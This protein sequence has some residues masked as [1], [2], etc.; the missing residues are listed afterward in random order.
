V[1]HKR[2]SYTVALTKEGLVSGGR[3]REVAGSESP[4]CLL[5]VC[6]LKGLHIPADA[7]G[8]SLGPHL[9]VVLPVAT[10]IS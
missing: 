4:D 6:S 9:G 8:G 10:R 7:L 1:A 3:F 5:G 2:S